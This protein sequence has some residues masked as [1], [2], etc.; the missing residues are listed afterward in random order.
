M[1]SKAHKTQ[2]EAFVWIWLPGETKPVVAGRLEVDVSRGQGNGIEAGMHDGATG[3]Q[4]I[5]RGTG[6]R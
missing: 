5:G 4:R 6:R 1:T 3:R 2:K